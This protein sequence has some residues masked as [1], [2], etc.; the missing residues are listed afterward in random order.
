ME[1]KAEKVVSKKGKARAGKLFRPRLNK[2]TEE[3]ME[4]RSHLDG[5]KHLLNPEISMKLQFQLGADLTVAFDDHEYLTDFKHL[6]KSLKLTELWAIRSLEAFKKLKSTQ[7]MYGV[8]HGAANKNL[9]IKSAKFTDKHFEAIALGG[10]YGTRLQMYEMIDYVLPHVSEEK[11]RHLLGIGEI[12][13][14]FNAV[15]RGV[16]LFDCVSPTRRARNGSLYICYKC[17]SSAFK[18]FATNIRLS[19]FT[20]DKNPI[21]PHCL[22]LT[23]QGFSKAYLRHLFMSNEILFHNLATYH[24]V[25]FINDLM[26]KIRESIKNN[27]FELLKNK[28]L[29]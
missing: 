1:E 8:I 6:E 10:I 12:E 19:K 17:G 15:E 28:W 20:N 4:F 7:L 22:C 2:I 3:G 21:D 14:L 27:S 13:D 16:D 11:P 9:R 24:N 18:N 29:S 25:F 23:C 26:K 5:S